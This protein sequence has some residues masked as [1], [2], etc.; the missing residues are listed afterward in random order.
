[1]I[2]RELKAR[3][4]QVFVCLLVPIED[5]TET[6]TFIEVNDRFFVEDLTVPQYFNQQELNDFI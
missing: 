4:G 2:I 5:V 6:P 1:M 3:L